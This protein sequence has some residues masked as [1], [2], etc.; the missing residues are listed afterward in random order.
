MND[1]RVETD[2]SV[3]NEPKPIQQTLTLFKD[4]VAYDFS[5]DEPEMITMVDPQRQR[6]VLFD[7]KRQVQLP[8][9][10]QKFM[11]FM[12]SAHEQVDSPDLPNLLLNR[13][14]AKRVYVDAEQKTVRVGE[15]ILR[16]EAS[17]QTPPQAEMSVYYAQFADASAALNAW[18]ASSPPPFARNA[19]NAAIAAQKAIPSEITRT[20]FFHKGE[21]VIEQV[22]TCRLHANWRLSKDDEAQIESVGRMLV[23]YQVVDV[24][25]FYKKPEA[26]PVTT[27]AK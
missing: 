19:L 18:R 17:L 23:S 13:E 21:R 2:I 11:Q 15:K 10:M 14:D 12:K 16:Y 27:A 7:S 24:P 1:F 20:A 22:V 5:R 8:I 3:P 26:S 6:I 9:D 4:G 25:L